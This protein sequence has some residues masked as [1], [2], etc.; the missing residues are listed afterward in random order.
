MILIFGPREDFLSSNF[1]ACFAFFAALFC[2]RSSDWLLSSLTFSGDVVKHP[3]IGTASRVG[4][5][6]DG[7]RV[8][9]SW[10]VKHHHWDIQME[11]LTCAKQSECVAYLMRHRTRRLRNEIAWSASFPVLLVQICPPDNIWQTA[12]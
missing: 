11:N 9:C 1:S 5:F 8:D 4:F 6:G 3:L 10:I 7:E 12:L 2:L